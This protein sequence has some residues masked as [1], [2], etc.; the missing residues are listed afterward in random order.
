VLRSIYKSTGEI[1]R[2]PGLMDNRQVFAPFLN[3]AMLGRSYS[4]DTYQYHQLAVGMNTESAAE[5]V[6]GQITALKTATAHPIIQSLPF[7]LSSASGIF[8]EVRSGL[9]VLSLFFHD[10]RRDE[11]YLTLEHLASDRAGGEWPVLSIRYAPAREEA[12][13]IESAL[14]KMRRFLMAL[15]APIVPGMTKIR[16]AGGGVHYSGTLPMRR[17]KTPWGLSKNCQSYDIANMFV[18]D[19]S[20]MPFLPAKNLTFTLMAN[21]SRVGSSI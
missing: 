4:P 15:G 9:G 10:R 17:D 1:V 8:S 21:A 14:G 13:A 16:A 3:L 5:Y 7:D 11:N 6:H 20:A 19:G 12:G 18:V 2:L